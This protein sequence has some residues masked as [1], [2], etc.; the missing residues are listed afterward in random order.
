MSKFAKLLLIATSLAPLLGAV[1]VNQWA[2][3]EKKWWWWVVATVLLTLACWGVLALFSKKLQRNSFTVTE[4]ESQ[5]KEVLVF[6]L[7]YLLPFISSNKL[8][9][10]GEWFTGIYIIAVI[11]FSLMHA[12][13]F[14]FNPLMSLFGYH[15]YSVKGSDGLRYLLIATDPIRRP[16]QPVDTVSLAHNI[17]LQVTK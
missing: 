15:F 17:K 8:S 12:D 11:M 10:T 16:G 2:T 14:H 4:F 1:A 9:F 6:L 7:T 13:A 5:D 3:G